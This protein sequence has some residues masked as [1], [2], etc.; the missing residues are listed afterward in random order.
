[1][2]ILEK[3]GVQKKIATGYS[4][5]SLLF[6]VLYPIARGDFKGLIIQ[7]ILCTVTFGFSWFV[8]PFVYN[9]YF[10]RRLVVQGWTPATLEDKH[11]LIKKRVIRP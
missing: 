3:N 4:F 8:T 11:Y 10:I 6:G 7:L 2:I 5:K 9:Y 1:M